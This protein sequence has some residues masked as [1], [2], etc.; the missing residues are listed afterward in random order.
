MIVGKSVHNHR[1]ERLF[2]NLPAVSFRNQAYVWCRQ[3]PEQ[4]GTSTSKQRILPQCKGTFLMFLLFQEE[5]EAFGID[6]DELLNT[7]DDGSTGNVPDTECPINYDNLSQSI[8]C[9][10]LVN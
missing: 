4:C 10:V 8:D 1:I 5:M 3:K 2:E 9:V 6:W 7:V